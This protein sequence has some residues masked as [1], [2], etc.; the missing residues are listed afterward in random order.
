MDSL[1]QLRVNYLTFRVPGFGPKNDTW[2][3]GNG[4]KGAWGHF[5]VSALDNDSAE[6]KTRDVP[7][8]VSTTQKR[9]EV[10]GKALRTTFALKV[11]AGYGIP[12]KPRKCRRPN[13]I[14]LRCCPHKI[15][16]TSE[17]SRFF[18]LWTSM[19][20]WPWRTSVFWRSDL[21]SICCADK[22]QTILD[23]GCKGTTYHCLF[24]ENLLQ[25]WTFDW[26]LASESSLSVA[27]GVGSLGGLCEVFTSNFLLLLRSDVL[28]FSGQHGLVQ[29][30]AFR[31]CPLGEHSALECPG[32]S[33]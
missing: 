9:S 1:V 30:G 33:W 24:L 4:R 7:V 19:L 11:Q 31:L 20:G 10:S 27:C 13:T 15:A 17:T 3:G 23:Q 28:I 12:Y 25:S 6:D 22:L 16:F 21:H 18:R 8:W 2:H 32:H 5:S 14:W 26:Q 29:V